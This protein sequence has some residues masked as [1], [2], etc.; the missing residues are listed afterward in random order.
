[1]DHTISQKLQNIAMKFWKRKKTYLRN[2]RLCSVNEI[3]K[4]FSISN[5]PTD[6][7]VTYFQN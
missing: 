4:Q 3:R 1:M 2:N 5:N 7:E 6:E